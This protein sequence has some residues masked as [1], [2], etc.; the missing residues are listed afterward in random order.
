M[1]T[2]FIGAVEVQVSACV[3]PVQILV[4]MELSEEIL[5]SPDSSADPLSLLVDFRL[6]GSLSSSSTS[7]TRL[8]KQ[9]LLLV[10]LMLAVFL[11]LCLYTIVIDSSS[12]RCCCFDCCG[13]VDMITGI[14]SRDSDQ[15]NFINILIRGLGLADPC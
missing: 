9:L 14:G 1:V 6:T 12:S 5:T 2:A 8:C 7:L 4:S 10:I 3:V 13:V 11:V 15:H